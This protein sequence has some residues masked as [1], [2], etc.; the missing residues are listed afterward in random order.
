MSAVIKNRKSKIEN[1][2]S[3][4]RGFTLIEMIVATLLLAIAVVGALAAFASATQSSSTSERLHTVALLAQ[5]RLTEVELQSDTLSGGEQQGDFGEE[6]PEYR[7]RQ[8]VEPTEYQNLYKVT[9]TVQWGPQTGPR[10]RAFTTF[11]R[12]DQNQVPQENSGTDAT[13][14]GATGGA[15]GGSGNGGQTRP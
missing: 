15:N 4:R 1:R 2:K 14:A 6:F 10:E 13:G 3:S 5:R 11:I 7:W 12:S 8:V 9:L